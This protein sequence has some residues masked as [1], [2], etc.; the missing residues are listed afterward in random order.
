MAKETKDT[1]SGK[2]KDQTFDVFDEKV[3]TWCRK[4]FGDN[5]A[6][7]LWHNK[8]TDIDNLDLNDEDNDTFTFEM[9]CATVYEVLALKSP[10]EADHLYQSDRASGR[11]S[12]S[13]NTASDAGRGS[14]AISRRSS[15]TKLLDNCGGYE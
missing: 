8:L 10:K 3:L 15:Q 7:G 5:Y 13:L 11:R 12:G 1:F 9:Y 6:K 2:S 14:S 4:Q